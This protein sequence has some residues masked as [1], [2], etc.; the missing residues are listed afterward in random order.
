[1]FS[2]GRFAAER[3]SFD[4]KE[5]GREIVLPWTFFNIGPQTASTTT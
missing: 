4:L 2:G 5:V 3:L 1:M